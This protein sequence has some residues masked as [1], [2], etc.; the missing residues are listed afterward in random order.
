MHEAKL[1]IQTE[2][3]IHF[4]DASKLKTHLL[5]DIGAV[6]DQKLDYFAASIGCGRAE[7]SITKLL[8]THTGKQ[9]GIVFGSSDGINGSF[10]HRYTMYIQQHTLQYL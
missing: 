9:T 8:S 1:N 6:L 5:V 2:P 7:W 3:H 4:N 10:K